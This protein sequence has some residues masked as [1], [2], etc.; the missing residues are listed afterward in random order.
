MIW[1]YASNKANQIINVCKNTEQNQ[2]D[3]SG[4]HGRERDIQIDTLCK[5]QK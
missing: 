2:I 3:Q 5:V 1:D 4:E